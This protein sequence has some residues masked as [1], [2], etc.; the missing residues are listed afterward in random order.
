[1][2]PAKSD[3]INS[4]HHTP[5]STLKRK[6]PDSSVKS[7]DANKKA[8]SGEN[9]F[10]AK[11][12]SGKKKASHQTALTQKLATEKKKAKAYPPR[13]NVPKPEHWQQG[14]SSSDESDDEGSDLPINDNSGKNHGGPLHSRRVT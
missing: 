13:Q 14:T 8:K 3:G 7:G 12:S 10:E 9:S 11:G 2:T 1:M 6:T 5:L 4:A